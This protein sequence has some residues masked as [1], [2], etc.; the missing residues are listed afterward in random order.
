MSYGHIPP[1]ARV[2]A[3]EAYRTVGE[4]GVGETQRAFGS[5][6]VD[7]G[8]RLRPDVEGGDQGPHGAAL[9]VHHAG[10]VGWGVHGDGGTREWFARD[11]TLGERDARRPG[12]PPHG[13]HQGRERGEVVG[14]H[15]E[16]RAS[17][18][19]KIEVRVRMPV[20][21]TVAKHERR[22][23]DG[24]SDDPLVHDLAARLETA[25]EEGVWGATDPEVSLDGHFQHPSPVLQAHGERLLG[26]YVLAGLEGRQRDLGVD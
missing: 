8:L 17:A 19:L 7:P 10:Y 20:L 15:V 23:G 24:L 5:V 6:E 1:G 16:H 21:R 25:A 11:R 22:Y 12:D 18:R 4:V 14:P 2:R 9:E 26:V 13:P 3:P